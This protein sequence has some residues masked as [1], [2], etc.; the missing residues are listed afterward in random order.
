MTSSCAEFCINTNVEG[1]WNVII[2][3]I[4]WSISLYSRYVRPSVD[5]MTENQLDSVGRFT[6]WL[7]F[8]SNPFNFTFINR[9][10]K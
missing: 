9:I 5:L 4:L 2:I 1:C 6:P 3:I 8:A 7:C 10:G